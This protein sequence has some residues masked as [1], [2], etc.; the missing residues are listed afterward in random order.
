MLILGIDPGT[1]TT[2]YGIIEIAKSK[3]QPKLVDF[4]V[5][6]TKPKLSDAERLQILADD[7]LKLIKKYKPGCVGVEKLFFTTNQKTVMAVSQARGA[8]LYV[9]QKSKI[10]IMEF[11]PLQVKS[12]ICGYGKADKKQV[13]YMVQKTFKL[14]AVPKPDDAADALAVALCAG[15][16][17][18]K[19]LSR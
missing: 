11:T 12:F 7:I 3:D 14:K 5:I 19:A 10:P 15:F 8:V 9:L 13:Q 1:A 17:H 18:N 4:G 2:G 16:F 6:S